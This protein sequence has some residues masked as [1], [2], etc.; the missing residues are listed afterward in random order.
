MDKDALEASDTNSFQ[1][2][3]TISV[4]E[5]LTESAGGLHVGK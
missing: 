2:W 4:L 5:K 1:Q 3:L